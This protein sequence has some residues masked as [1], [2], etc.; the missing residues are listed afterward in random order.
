MYI[1]LYIYI[2]MIIDSSK[3]ESVL[4]PLSSM[5]MQGDANIIAK[6]LAALWGA[7]DFRVIHW[8]NT[9]S[10]GQWAISTLVGGWA[11]P[12]K[13]MKVNWDDYSLYIMGM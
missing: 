2:Y 13:N 6:A 11:T 9:D 12:L 7:G 5:A 10:V 1:T 3:I 4:D 8:E